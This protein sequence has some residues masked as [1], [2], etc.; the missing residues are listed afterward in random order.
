MLTSSLKK[1]WN[2][3]VRKLKLKTQDASLID[4]LMLLRFGPQQTATLKNPILNYAS[5]ARAT[6]LPYTTVEDLIK[7]GVILREKK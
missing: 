4:Y 1:H 5:I 3:D 2:L 6:K 7:V